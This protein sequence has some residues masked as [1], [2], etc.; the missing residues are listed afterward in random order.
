MVCNDNVHTQPFGKLYLLPV[1]SSAVNG[2]DQ[3]GSL[4]GHCLDSPGIE[5][6]SLF[7]T[8]RDMKRYGDAK[9]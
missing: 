9:V 2:D 5:T 6:V 7:Q 4:F 1:S 8:V 3:P